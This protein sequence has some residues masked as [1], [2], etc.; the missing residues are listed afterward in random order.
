MEGYEIIES[1]SVEVGDVITIETCFGISKFPIT[2]VTKK[3]S[4][5]LRKS[6]GYEH[7]FQRSIGG[8]MAKP[9]Q[10]WNMS[11]YTVYRKIKPE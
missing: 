10:K 2:R 1:G 9:K 8:D 3:I 7:T 5:S 4:Y 11:K 6:D